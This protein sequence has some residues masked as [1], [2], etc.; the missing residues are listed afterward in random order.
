MNSETVLCPSHSC[1]TGTIMLGIVMRDGRVAF[2]SDQLVVTDEFVKIAS[3]GRAPEKRFRFAGP[4][5]KTGCGQWKEGRCGV[6]DSVMKYAASDYNEAELPACS[7]RPQCRWFGQNGAQ[8]CSVCPDVITDT[9][10]EI[11]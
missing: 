1:K 7:I 3:E 11:G 2:S 6:I 10:E 5:V 8:A 4:C 9:R